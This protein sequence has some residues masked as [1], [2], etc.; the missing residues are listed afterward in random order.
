LWIG[1]IERFCKTG[2]R[3]VA[4]IHRGFSTSDTTRFRNKPMWELPIELRRKLPNVPILNDPSHIAGRRDL[5][6]T[7]AQTAM[8]IGL[9]GFIIE[10][11]PDPDNAWSDA[12]QQVTPEALD[13]ILH[14][15]KTRAPTS[16]DRGFRASLTDLREE[17]DRIDLELLHQLALRMRVVEQIGEYKK[18]QNVMTLQMSRWKEVLADRLQ[19]AEELGL[20]AGYVKDLYDVIHEESIK[21][22][23]E[24]M[25]Q[26]DPS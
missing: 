8:D 12:S 23:S 10:S 21:R 4:A 19:R 6:E 15:L 20:G 1:A 9:D 17:I 2:H 22:Q 18:E 3:K 11:H 14:M 7:V 16:N 5:I 13:Q 26:D 24:I 25:S